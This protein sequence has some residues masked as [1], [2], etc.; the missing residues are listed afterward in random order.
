MFLSINTQL[1]NNCIWQNA[2]YIAILMDGAG[3]YFESK[4]CDD[5]TNLCLWRK[6]MT[7]TKW[8]KSFM[9]FFLQGLHFD[10]C[11]LCNAKILTWKPF[12]QIFWKK[13]NSD[14]IKNKTMYRILTCFILPKM[15]PIWLISLRSC[16]KKK[17]FYKMKESFMFFQRLHFDK[18]ILYIMQIRYWLENR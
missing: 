12:K 15:Y 4:Q 17:T 1:R 9:F 7:L 3:Q 8:K 2:L 5:K 6:R 18:C 16:K 13:C 14:V 10:K 11:I